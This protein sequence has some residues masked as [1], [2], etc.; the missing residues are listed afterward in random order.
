[1]ADGR[2]ARHEAARHVH[3]AAAP[4][5]QLKLGK[6][7]LRID[8]AKL[9]KTQGLG[10]LGQLGTTD[11]A[12]GLELLEAAGAPVTTLGADTVRG[13]AAEGYRVTVDLSRYRR[14]LP[15]R[16]RVQADRLLKALGKTT[17]PVDVWIGADGLVHRVALATPLALPNAGK[18]ALRTSFDIFDYG[19]QL[20]LQAPPAAQVQDA[21]KLLTATKRGKD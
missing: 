8:V 6:P 3:E 12:Q 17:M 2:R 16:Q 5:A 1:M 4:D 21:T 20:D 19:A 11:P 9:A 15:A 18:L 13:Q 10:Q 7:W 14:L